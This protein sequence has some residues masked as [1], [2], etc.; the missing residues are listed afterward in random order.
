MNYNKSLP[1]FEEED[2]KAAESIAVRNKV[3]RQLPEDLTQFRVSEVLGQGGFG[4]VFKGEVDIENGRVL[5]VAIKMIYS[6]HE[7]SSM[8]NELKML[9][10]FLDAPHILQLLCHFV[11]FPSPQMLKLAEGKLSDES[12]VFTPDKPATFFVVELH[13]FTLEKKLEDMK[14]NIAPQII[15]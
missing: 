14:G 11:A 2:R 7:E 6:I 3:R 8:K 12:L 4:I 13:P 10:K 9:Q 5:D 15:K 1:N